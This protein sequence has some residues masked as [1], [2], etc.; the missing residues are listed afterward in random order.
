MQITSKVVEITTVTT[1]YDDHTDTL[2]LCTSLGL[3]PLRIISKY[4]LIHDA[5][6]HDKLYCIGAL[7]TFVIS[8]KILQSLRWMSMQQD[9]TAQY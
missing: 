1:N 9:I 3:G 8:M 7:G 2:L 4:K 5:R 6:G